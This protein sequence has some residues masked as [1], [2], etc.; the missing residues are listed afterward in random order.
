MIAGNHDLTFDLKEYNKSLANAFHKHINPP[1]D[2]VKTKALLTDCIYL[3]DSTYNLKGYNIYGSPYTPTFFDWAF[4]LDI[5]KPL[6]AKWEQIPLD[7]DIL[8]THGPPYNIL[9][10]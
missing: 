4:N 9:D 3:E 10:K 1:I 8:I 2:P 5:G 7:T 6:Q